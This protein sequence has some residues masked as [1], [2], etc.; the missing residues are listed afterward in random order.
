MPQ[1]EQMKIALFGATGKMGRSIRE[2]GSKY[3][4][5]PFSPSSVDDYIETAQGLDADVAIDVSSP[6]ALE[7]HLGTCQGRQIPL[8]IGTTGLTPDL[9]EAVTR[10]SKVIPIFLAANFSLGVAI[11]KAMLRHLGEYSKDAYIDIIEKHP[12]TKRDLPSGTALELADYFNGKK[13]MGDKVGP[14]NSE[15]LHIHSIRS[16]DHTFSHEFHFTFGAEELVLTH[17][18]YDRGVYAQGALKAAAFLTQC[19]PGLYTMED[20]INSMES[21]RETHI[22]GSASWQ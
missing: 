1:E 11:M 14:R 10:T 8:V 7:L 4:I 12:A 5:I 22:S 13:E 18:A 2:E 19:K 6:D 16:G 21:T 9:L 20:L 17:R 3:E 15:A